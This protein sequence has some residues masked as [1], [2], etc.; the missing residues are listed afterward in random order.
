VPVELERI[1]A[2]ALAKDPS[3]RYQHVDEMLVDLKHLRKEGETATAPHPATA[4]GAPQRRPRWKR[5]R[6][7]TALAILFIAAFFLL[8]P[9]LFEADLISEPKPVA[10][11]TFVNQ[12]GDKT[13]D[14]LAEAIPNRYRKTHPD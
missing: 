13:Y 5:L 8:R 12:T 14:Y 6:F 7:P 1:V 3:E 2:K 9:I 11:V 4:A 10:V